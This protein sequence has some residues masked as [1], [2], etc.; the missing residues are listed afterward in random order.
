MNECNCY[1]SSFDCVNTIYFCF[2]VHSILPP[3]SSL[4]LIQTMPLWTLSA[5]QKCGFLLGLIQSPLKSMGSRW[6]GANYQCCDWQPCSLHVVCSTLLVLFSFFKKKLHC[7]AVKCVWYSN[8]SFSF[9]YVT[10]FNSIPYHAGM[11]CK[12]SESNDKLWRINGTLVLCI[13]E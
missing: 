9:L 2:M 5:I 13:N 6:F 11:A 8:F 10:I 12:S 3:K 1:T 4:F 7:S